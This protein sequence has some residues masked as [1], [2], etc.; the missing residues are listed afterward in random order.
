MAFSVCAR[1]QVP[2]CAVGLQSSFLKSHSA[3]FVPLHPLPHAVHHSKRCSA[4][5]KSFSVVA[6]AKRKKGERAPTGGGGSGGGG[7]GGGASTKSAGSKQVSSGS[8]YQNETRKIILS[9]R[10]LRKVGHQ[11][12]LLYSSVLHFS[13]L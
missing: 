13:T 7:G 10:N 11:D 3:S 2:G 6:Q 12:V 1:L 4:P 9:V 8:A 5:N